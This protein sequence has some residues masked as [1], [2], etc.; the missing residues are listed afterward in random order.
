MKLLF[1]ALMLIFPAISFA[2]DVD[3][4]FI[5][6]ALTQSAG[7]IDSDNG[8]LASLTQQLE[9]LNQTLSQ[10]QNSINGTQT[11]ID[12]IT[13]DILTNKTNI[14]ALTKTNP[15]IQAAVELCNNTPQYCLTP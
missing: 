1:I 14:T 13:A 4:R 11:Q 15:P 9:S 2:D 12:A 3:P 10:I 6:A 7:V 5:Q 8:Q